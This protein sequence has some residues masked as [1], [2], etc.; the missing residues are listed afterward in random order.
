V[1]TSR[2]A[3]SAGN[4]AADTVVVAL[5]TSTP[6]GR[7]R[8]KAVSVGINDEGTTLAHARLSM[9]ANVSPQCRNRNIEIQRHCCIP[10]CLRTASAGDGQAAEEGLQSDTFEFAKKAIRRWSVTG[11]LAALCERIQNLNS[12]R[13]SMIGLCAFFDPKYRKDTSRNET[14]TPANNEQKLVCSAQHFSKCKKIQGT[15]L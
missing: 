8:K 9:L 3:E 2:L 12:M 6:Q 7:R 4:G 11:R 13:S 10:L 5:D 15:S 1:W 14:T